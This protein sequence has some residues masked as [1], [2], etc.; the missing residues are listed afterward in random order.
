MLLPGVVPRRTS[1]IVGRFFYIL[2]S[3]KYSYYFIEKEALFVWLPCIPSQTQRKMFAVSGF[4][5]C[6]GIDLL[7]AVRLDIRKLHSKQ[8]Q[9]IIGFVRCF[10]VEKLNAKEALGWVSNW[11][12][13][14]WV[15][16]LEEISKSRSRCLVHLNRA[17]IDIRLKIWRSQLCACVLYFE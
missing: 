8:V 1:S 10:G 4:S 14:D 16:G 5:F 17:W 9:R 13:K 7:T 2:F 11:G 12:R 6:S 3:L 15:F